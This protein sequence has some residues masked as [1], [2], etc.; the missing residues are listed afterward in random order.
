MS[1]LPVPWCR[2]ANKFKIIG[3]KIPIKIAG[4]DTPELRGKCPKEMVING[5]IEM[6]TPTLLVLIK[7][8]KWVDNWYV[9]DLEE[10]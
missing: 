7:A 4:I 8:W 5:E 1:K 10:L 6:I 2:R 9:D 3:F